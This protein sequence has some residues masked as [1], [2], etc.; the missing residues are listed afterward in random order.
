MNTP[1]LIKNWTNICLFYKKIL[2]NDK[3]CFNVILSS[4][5]EI[6]QARYVK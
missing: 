1:N 2:S 4:L 6:K 5:K 3:E